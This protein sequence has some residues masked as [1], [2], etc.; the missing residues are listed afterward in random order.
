MQRRVITLDDM[1]R[2]AFIQNN[3][4]CEFGRNEKT[5]IETYNSMV[6]WYSKYFG[7][8]VKI[9]KEDTK[10]DARKKELAKKGKIYKLF[11]ISSTPEI[12]GCSEKTILDNIDSFVENTITG[13]GSFP[14]DKYSLTLKVEHFFT[15]LER[16]YELNLCMKSMENFKYRDRTERLLMILKLL[17][18][19]GKTRTEIAESFGISENMLSE[20]LNLLQS[21]DGYEFLGFKMKMSDLERSENTYKSKVNPL[22]Y[23]ANMSEIYSLTIGLKLLSKGTVFEHALYPIADKIYSQLSDYAR[24]VIDKQSKIN[25]ITFD[26]QTMNFLN[27]ADLFKQEELAFTYFL[28]EPI[29]CEVT[30]RDGN[31]VKHITGTLHISDSSDEMFKKVVVRGEDGDIEINVHDVIRCRKA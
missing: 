18:S 17:H 23:A 28:K 1:L 12:L 21:N 13:V 9:N 22:F 5:K 19:G 3:H 8:W 27:T 31:Q 26:G 6:T 2:E 20:D 10:E 29:P 7:G 15:F 4:N 24:D 25:R 30:Y 11:G 16:K 14:R